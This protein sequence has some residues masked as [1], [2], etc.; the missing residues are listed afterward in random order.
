M[1]TET[2]QALAELLLLAPYL[3]SHLSVLEDEALE[4]AMIAIGWNPHKPKDLCLGTAFALVRDAGACEIKADTFMRE[5]TA[6]V[7]AAG[8]SATAF[9]W[10]GRILGSDGMSGQE[11]RFLQRAKTQLFE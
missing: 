2:R 9:E 11:N 3:D 7:R 5:R 4:R 10:L 8:E 6:I 1:T